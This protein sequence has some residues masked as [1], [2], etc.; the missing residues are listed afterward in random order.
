MDSFI[1]HFEASFSMLKLEYTVSLM[2]KLI[3]KQLVEVTLKPPI[4]HYYVDYVVSVVVNCHSLI[5][6]CH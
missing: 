5:V 6:Q 3:I 1:I 2:L 4:P